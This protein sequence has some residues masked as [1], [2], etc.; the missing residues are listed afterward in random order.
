MDFNYDVFV[1]FSRLDITP[2][3]GINLHGYFHQRICEG[4]LDAL[5]INAIAVKKY[6]ETVVL[7]TLDTMSCTTEFFD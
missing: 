3:L 6:N 1:G 5:E 4:V 2:P 7:M